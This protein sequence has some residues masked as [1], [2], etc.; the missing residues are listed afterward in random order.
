MNRRLN[1]ISS[2]RAWCPKANRPQERDS[3]SKRPVIRFPEGLS[4]AKHA[5]ALVL[6]AAVYVWTCPLPDRIGLLGIMVAFALATGA[7]TAEEER[8]HL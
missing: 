8:S 6:L 7:S 2:I 3:V 4:K 1:G 5:L